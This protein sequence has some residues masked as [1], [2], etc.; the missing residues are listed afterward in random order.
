[1]FEKAGWWSFKLGRNCDRNSCFLFWKAAVVGFR[2]Q[3]S[4]FPFQSFS[5]LKGY[6]SISLQ[7]GLGG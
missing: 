6:Q 7:P 1:M 2:F 4:R 3:Q 5:N